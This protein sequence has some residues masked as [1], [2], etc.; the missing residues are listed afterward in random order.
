[1]KWF[2]WKK[3]NEKQSKPIQQYSVGE[4]EEPELPPVERVSKPKSN[5][6]EI[7]HYI[8]SQCETIMENTKELEEGRKEYHEVCDYLADIEKLKALPEEK[9]AELKET[10]QNVRKLT[11]ARE[12]YRKAGHRMEDAIFLQMQQ[13][14]EEMPDEIRRLQANEKYQAAVKRDM[15]YL[16]SEKEQLAIRQEQLTE[17]QTTLQQLLY[18]LCGVCGV[19]IVLL[20]VLKEGFRLH[21]ENAFFLLIF[22]VAMLTFGIFMKRQYN[23]TEL[24][25]INVNRNYAIERENKMK[26]KYVNVTNAVDYAC[27]KYHVKSGQELLYEWE[28]YMDSVKQR[29]KYMETS[30]DLEYYE[31]KL[32]RILHELNLTDEKL[33]FD[34]I[35]ILLD[36]EEIEKERQ[37]LINRQHKLQEHLDYNQSLIQKARS[38]VNY[39]SQN[40]E[41]CSADIMGIVL[42]MNQLCQGI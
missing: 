18:C 10:V 28:Q 33:W 7:E 13:K 15:Q 21:C 40:M 5:R 3:K 42:S 30:D 38:Q 19:G 34:Q 26:V 29:K 41:K 20:F 17:E 32:S 6:E 35:D 23:I 14:E 27:A 2:H 31:E 8:V 4:E 11:N 39:L 22:V 1:M 25:K 37:N 12:N 9:S 24:H 36:D 16:S